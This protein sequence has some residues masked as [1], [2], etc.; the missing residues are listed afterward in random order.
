[1]AINTKLELRQS[2]SLVMTPQLQ[3]AIKLLQLSNMELASFVEDE[4]ER[5]PLLEHA[6]PDEPNGLADDRSPAATKDEGEDGKTSAASDEASAETGD[7]EDWVDLETG[8]GASQTNDLD[9]EPQDMF[10]DSDTFTPGAVTDSGL[11]RPDAGTPRRQRR[12][13]PISKPMW[14]RR[15]R[16]HPSRRAAQPRFRRSAH[17]ADRPASHRYDR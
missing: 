5:N 11:E 7:G 3:Q 17:A 10:P 8:N 15:R 9:A 6:D 12:R 1:M 16:S 4:L 14:P 2:H 13:T